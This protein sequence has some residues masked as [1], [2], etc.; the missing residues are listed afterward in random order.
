MIQSLNLQYV[1]LDLSNLRLFH[2]IQQT[3]PQ[4]KSP[5]SLTMPELASPKITS[6]GALYWKNLYLD[7]REVAV[8][9]YSKSKKKPKKTLAIFTGVG[10]LG[11]CA[12]TTP[13]ELK[14]RDQLLM[15]SNDMTLV[16]ESIRNPHASRYLDQVEKYYDLGVVRNISLGI[17]SVMWL[18]NYDSS[19]GIYSS[20]CDYLKPRFTEMIDRVL[21]VGFLG[22]WW[23]LHNIMRD[24]D[25]NPIEFINKT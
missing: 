16:G 14:Y 1:V 4:T 18:D 13:D 3:S 20:Q 9:T 2:T 21:D 5:P 12:S 6:R 23:I 10:I 11:Y 17:L 25:V 19:C 22:R 24:F 7:Y 15:S 8:E